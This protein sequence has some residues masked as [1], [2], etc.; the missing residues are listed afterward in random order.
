MTPS[1]I[2]VT[3]GAGFIGSHT[4][5]ELLEHGFEVV[6][7][8]DF[9]NSSPRAL[10]RVERIAGRRPVL[11]TGDIRDGELLEKTLTEHR[12][13]AVIHFAAKKAVGEST[14]IP[15]DY[16]DINVNGTLQLLKAMRRAGV[17]SLVFSSSC[18]LYGAGYRGRSLSEDDP[19]APTNP[20]ARTKL[21]CE[22]LLAAACAAD[23]GLR[24]IA[25]RY[26]NPVGAHPSSLLGEDPRGVP[27]N[28]MPYL[29]QVAVGRLPALTIFGDD[30]DTVDGTGVRDYIHVVDVADGH[31]V[32][33][34]HLGDEA[35]MSLFNLGT[36]M[37]TSVLELAAAFG[38]AAQRPIPIVKAPRRPG[39]VATLQADARR[40][41][42]AWGW[43]TRRDLAA[44]CRDAWAFQEANPYGYDA[45]PATAD[46]QLTAR[47]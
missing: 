35:G 3:G 36:G 7:V 26:F 9:S 33:L 6:V 25:L 19:C 13:E 27:N 16:Y 23:P 38:E 42:A 21:T 10:D 18:S 41:D 11:V 30:Y 32:A 12:I 20:Y 34:A 43:R 5:V 47:V 45:P 31:R 22:H 14:E 17:G 2:L 40:V 28:V 15:L 24:V 4:C 29:A 37:G 39:D 44:M 1:R 8:D 46:P